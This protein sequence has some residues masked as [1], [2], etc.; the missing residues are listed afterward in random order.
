MVQILYF[1][2]VLFANRVLHSLLL[3]HSVL[4]PISC[5]TK[6][7]LNMNPELDEPAFEKPKVDLSL[8]M[9]TLNV[10]LTNKQFQYLMQL[11]DAMN[12]MQLGL[13][14]RQYR[15]YNIRES[16]SINK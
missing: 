8:E 14:Y 16:Y 9:E 6:L 10:G 15:P 2:L 11:G 12:R 3:F 7:K 1:P 13:P 5:I 4:G